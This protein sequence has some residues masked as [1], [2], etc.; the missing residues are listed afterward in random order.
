MSSPAVIKKK[1]DLVVQLLDFLKQQNIQSADL[2]SL[3]QAIQNAPE[4]PDTGVL[5]SQILTKYKEQFSGDAAA[6]F[7]RWVLLN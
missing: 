1:N 7:K 6:I 5:A 4:Q 3:R 2:D